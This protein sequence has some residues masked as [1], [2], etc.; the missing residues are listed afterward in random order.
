MLSQE[1]RNAVYELLNNPSVGHIQASES[2]NAVNYITFH[3]NEG[4]YPSEIRDLVEKIFGCS[5]EKLE[6][7]TWPEKNVDIYERRYANGHK[8]DISI[9]GYIKKE[10]PQQE[11]AQEKT[12]DD[13]TS[14]QTFALACHNKW[15]CDECVSKC[16]HDKSSSRLTAEEILRRET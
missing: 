4:A 13:Y 7:T 9:R 11:G 3:L 14:D 6:V 8:L 1:T 10:A 15:T 16:G 2:I 5:F 12:Q